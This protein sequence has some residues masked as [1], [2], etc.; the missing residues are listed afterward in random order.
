MG[1]LTEAVRKQA[2]AELLSMAMRRRQIDEREKQRN[3][4]NALER[5][6]EERFG[7]PEQVGA[8]YEDAAQLLGNTEP[9]KMIKTDVRRHE[10]FQNVMERLEEKHKKVQAEERAERVVRLQRFIGSD[11]QLKRTRLRWK[12]AAAILGRRGELHEDAGQPLEA[13]R[14]WSSLRT[15]KQPSEHEAIEKAKVKPDP[16][17]YR[18]DRKRRDA[19]LA[20]LKEMVQK[21]RLMDKTSWSAFEARVNDPRVTAMRDARG[22]T[23]MELFEEFQDDLREGRIPNLQISLKDEEEFE[24]IKEE[25][26]PPAKRHRFDPPDS[27]VAAAHAAAAAAAAAASRRAGGEVS[28]LD[29]MIMGNNAGAADE[30]SDSD[31][32]DDDEDDPLMGVVNRAAAAKRAAEGFG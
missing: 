20:C 27:S 2:F 16:A 14:I 4:A 1:D 24:E 10:V 25:E 29:A 12:D 18:E 21:G 5:L 8:S 22:A 13:L 28:A 7:A 30:S 3:A 31:D 32:D 26:E 9:W 17:A 23:S 19:F 15:L 6:I 11:P